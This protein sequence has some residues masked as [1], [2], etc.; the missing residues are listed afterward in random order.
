VNIGGVRPGAKSQAQELQDAAANPGVK[1]L[2]HIK[3][4][5]RNFRSAA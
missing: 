3:K 5:R 2:S 4:G 1:V